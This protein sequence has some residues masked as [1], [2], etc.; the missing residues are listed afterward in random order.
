MEHATLVASP[1]PL[2]H[3]DGVHACPFDHEGEALPPGPLV[4]GPHLQLRERD[5]DAG[6]G[7]IEAWDQRTVERRQELDGDIAAGVEARLLHGLEDGREGRPE[8]GAR[9]DHEEGREQDGQGHE[10]TERSHL[11][12]VSLL[13]S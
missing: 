2:E 11:A 1:G 10:S 4:G 5:R 12:Q 8:G 6:Q 3:Q 9:A 7:V 13:L